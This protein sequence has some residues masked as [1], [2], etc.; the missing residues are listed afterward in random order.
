MMCA[1]LF[2]FLF[3]PVDSWLSNYINSCG[4]SLPTCRNQVK[5]EYLMSLEATEGFLEEMGAQLLTT[6]AISTPDAALQGIDAVTASDVANV[7]GAPS[8][9]ELHSTE[10]V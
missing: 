5:A 10:S 8:G 9:V 2:L 6:G 7:S 4:V 3:F 1:D